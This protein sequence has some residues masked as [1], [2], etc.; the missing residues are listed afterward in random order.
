VSGQLHAPAA[1]PPGK[2]SRYPLYRRLGGPQ[3]QS[4]R[5]GLQLA[6]RG[7]ISELCYSSTVWIFEDILKV[8]TYKH[9]VTHIHKIK[10]F[11]KTPKAQHTILKECFCLEGS[12]LKWKVL[13]FARQWLCKTV[14][15]WLYSLLH[16][17]RYFAVTCFLSHQSWCVH[18]RNMFLLQPWKWRQQDSQKRRYSPKRPHN[19]TL[20]KQQFMQS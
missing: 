7:T 20:Q 6:N 17:H 4:G 2:S 16:G 11:I 18:H 9:D 5:H 1:L 15:L 12:S 10:C 13:G 14:N 19:I 3:S 8:L